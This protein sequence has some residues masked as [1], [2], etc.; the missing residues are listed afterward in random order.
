MSNKPSYKEI[1]KPFPGRFTGNQTLTGTWRSQK[2]VIENEKCIKCGN[3]QVFCPDASIFFEDE[4]YQV[5]YDYCKGCGICANEC[6]VNA[7]SM[8]REE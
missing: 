5:N 1:R 2:P 7:I 6:P 3:C 8:E 4:I